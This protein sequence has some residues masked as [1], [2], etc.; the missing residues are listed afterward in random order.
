M[1]RKER[2][3]GEETEDESRGQP[4]L[5]PWV[6]AVSLK[7]SSNHDVICERCSNALSIKLH[8]SVSCPDC[9]GNQKV[10]KGSAQ[11]IS[12]LLVTFYF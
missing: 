11:F 5:N 2:R 7:I 8:Q 9:S 6:T 10:D 3:G 12:D 4:L 1:S